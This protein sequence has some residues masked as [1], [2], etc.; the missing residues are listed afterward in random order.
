ML[1]DFGIRLSDFLDYHFNKRLEIVRYSLA[2]K[3]AKEKPASDF[4][5]YYQE[6]YQQM[7]KEVVWIYERPNNIGQ[8]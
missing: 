7:L 4:E 8:N 6:G 1:A 3:R 5:W 2:V